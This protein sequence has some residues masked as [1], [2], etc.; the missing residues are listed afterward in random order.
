MK[1]IIETKGLT[2]RFGKFNAVDSISL[3]VKKG[4][5]YGF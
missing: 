1:N 3:S 2:K 4:E 5:I